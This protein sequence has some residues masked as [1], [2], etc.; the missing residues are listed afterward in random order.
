[1]NQEQ[2]Q[3]SNLIFSKQINAG[4]KKA[5][6]RRLTLLLDEH[7]RQYEKWETQYKPRL[8]VTRQKDVSRRYEK[9]IQALKIVIYFLTPTNERVDNEPSFIY[10]TKRKPKPKAIEYKK[11]KQIGYSQPA[12]KPPVY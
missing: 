11:P 5:M 8:N 6:V 9:N 7:E 4:I 1:M 3:I 10:P 2:K 12:L